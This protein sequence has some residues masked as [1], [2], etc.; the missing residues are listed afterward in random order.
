MG[1]QKSFCLTMEKNAPMTL[2]PTS[3]RSLG[4]SNILLPLILPDQMARQ[5]F[6][7]FLKASII[8][9]YQEDKASWDQVLD[10][11]LFS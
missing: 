8:I 7:K 11:I 4:L 3:A 6:N 10:P 2:W 5:N 1:V 9:L